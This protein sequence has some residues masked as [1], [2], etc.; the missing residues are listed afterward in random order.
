MKTMNTVSEVLFILSEVTI[1]CIFNS[2]CVIGKR[3]M[4]AIELNNGNISLIHWFDRE[5][6]VKNY[7][8]REEKIERA[9][10]SSFY[11][12]VLKTDTLK[13]IFNR[14]KLLT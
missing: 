9:D 4:T 5:R 1:P 8:Y 10:R 7:N 12:M 11:R 2:G 14:I 13:N 3:G 6:N